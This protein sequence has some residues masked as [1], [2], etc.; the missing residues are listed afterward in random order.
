ME[1]SMKQRFNLLYKQFFYSTGAELGKRLR[2]LRNAKGLTIEQLAER[3]YLNPT[4]YQK[5]ENEQMLDFTY[6][7]L[8]ALF[9][10]QKIKIILED[11]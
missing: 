2:D 3:V 9:Y 10:N 8:L 5:M 4:Q 11:K 7:A 1:L 6:L